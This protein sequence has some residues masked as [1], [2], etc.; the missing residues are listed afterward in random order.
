MV[1]LIVVPPFPVPEGAEGEIQDEL[2]ITDQASVPPPRFVM[3]RVWAGGLLPPCCT[4]KDRL[5]GVKPMVA[6]TGASACAGAVGDETSCAKL[7]SSADIPRI[8]RSPA[9]PLPDGDGFPIPAAASGIVS[10]GS[11]FLAVDPEGVADGGVMCTGVRGE[12][13]ATVLGGVEG[14]LI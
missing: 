3:V 7:D 10:V 1:T 12:G 5:A 14:S 9:P 4:V 2:S 6:P 11:L 13:A 8:V